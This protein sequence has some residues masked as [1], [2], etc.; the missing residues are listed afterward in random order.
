M[1]VPCRGCGGD[2][3]RNDVVC[4][5][6]AQPLANALLSAEQLREPEV[7]WPLRVLVCR[8]CMLVQLPPCEGNPFTADYPFY[9]GVSEGWPEHCADLVRELDPPQGGHVLEVGSND[10]TL[11]RAF[12]EWRPDLR[13]LGVEPCAEVAHHALR[14]GLATEVAFWTEAYAGGMEAAGYQADLVLATNVLAHVPHLGD[15]LNGVRRVLARNGEFVAEVPYVL[16]MIAQGQYDQVYTEHH[17]YFS[18]AS[19]QRALT[20]AGLYVHGVERIPVHGGSLRVRAHSTGGRWEGRGNRQILDARDHERALGF[21]GPYAY[22]DF[23]SVPGDY[24]R[25]ALSRLFEARSTA[26]V[27]LGG[28]PRVVGYGASAKAAVTLNYLGLGPETIHAVADTTPAKQ[29]KYLPGCRI[30]VIAPHDEVVVPE[31]VVNFLWNWRAD[32]ERNIREQWGD[33][34]IVYLTDASS[35]SAHTVAA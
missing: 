20:L 2:V 27:R 26:A 12:T 32:S 22:L 35:R 13:V 33:V 23:A 31:L 34:P 10:G 24:K 17:S 11:L 3:Y 4:D 18:V 15:F 25:I 14:D 6:G 16:D 1:P 5:L 7:H 29:G 30:P 19:I 28:A 21:D 8:K 9:A